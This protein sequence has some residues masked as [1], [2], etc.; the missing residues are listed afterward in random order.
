MDNS[1]TF[2][3]RLFNENKGGNSRYAFELRKGLNKLGW[4]TN[5]YEVSKNPILSFGQEVLLGSSRKKN[6]IHFLCDTGQV[7]RSRSPTIT[8]V[9]GIASRYNYGIRSKKAEYI[10]RKR[11]E[12]ALRYSDLIITPSDSSRRDLLELF[13]FDENRIHVVQHGIDHAKFHPFIN[14]KDDELLEQLRELPKD[15]LLYI[16]NLDPRKNLETLLQAIES[17]SWP[18][19][20]N[21]VI[22]GKFVWG[23]KDLVERIEANPRIIYL[24]QLDE[25][26][27][28]PLYRRA[29]LFIFPSLY[30]GFGFPVLEALACG[31]PV[32]T[33]GKGN[34]ESFRLTGHPI[35]EEPLDPSEIASKVLETLKLSINRAQ[36]VESGIELAQG[37]KWSS[38]VQSHI[39]LYSSVMN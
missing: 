15:F 5:I 18:I 10:W 17:A 31:T 4:E 39:N 36:F 23:Q 9:H 22:V 28:A 1:V 30:E 19:E 38:A 32:I 2:T 13:D 21:L 6:L 24:G 35:I 3:S 27:I 16:G 7:F 25:V 14:D 11:V 29:R 8:T 12:L 20:L 37:F 26:F 33:T 34:L